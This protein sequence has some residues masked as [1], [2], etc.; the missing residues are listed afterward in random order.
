MPTRQDIVNEAKRWIGT[1]FHHQARVRGPHGGVDCIG[2]I[3]GVA[4]ALGIPVCDRIDYARKAHNGELRAALDEQMIRVNGFEP[5]DVLLFWVENTD[6]ETHVGIVTELGFVHAWDQ[7]A[8][9]KV[10]EH[11]LTAAWRK[12]IAQAYSFREV[13]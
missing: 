12:R 5:G 3:A 11:G 1:P 10:V 6:D 8:I 4:V 9:H 2:L 13:C 7:P